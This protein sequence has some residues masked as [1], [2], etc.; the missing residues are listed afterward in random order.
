MRIVSG[1]GVRGAV[2]TQS[3]V[4]GHVRYRTGD[5]FGSSYGCA[6]RIA[7]SSV[8]APGG[9]LDQQRDPVAV[10]WR[11]SGITMTFVSIV[12][13]RRQACLDQVGGQRAGAVGVGQIA[14]YQ[15]YMRGH[16][17]PHLSRRRRVSDTARPEAD[18]A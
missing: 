6:A 11:P 17:N 9:G 10:R 15:H 5:D 3:R 14:E 7:A 12:P 1:S 16:G 13:R 18:G 2:R 4:A 8:A